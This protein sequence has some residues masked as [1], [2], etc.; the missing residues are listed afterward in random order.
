MV[1]EQ[2]VSVDPPSGPAPGCR[3]G[4][5]RRQDGVDS[6]WGW[7]AIRDGFLEEAAALWAEGWGVSQG[8]I[9]ISGN[10]G[11]RPWEAL[12]AKPRVR[13]EGGR[14]ETSHRKMAS[15]LRSVD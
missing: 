15:G 13:P 7:V 2:C 14:S 1:P 9:L 11:A 12:T 5:G 4:L 3:W 10:R 8:S 6:T